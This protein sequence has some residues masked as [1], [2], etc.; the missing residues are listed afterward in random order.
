MTATSFGRYEVIAPLARGGMGEVYLAAL[1]SP[2]GFERKVVIKSVRA[3]LLANERMALMF[4]DEAR[5]AACLYHR[6]IVQTLE[7][8]LSPTGAYLVLEYVPGLDLFRLGKGLQAPMPYELAV[9]I[10]LEIAAALHHA[11]QAV[12]TEGQPLAIVHRD[13]TPSNVLLGDQGHVK[14]ADF[15]IAHSKSRL[16]ATRSGTLKGKCGYIAPEQIRG[17]TIDRRAD[18]FSLGVLFYEMT[19]GTSLYGHLKELE[20]MKAILNQ[21]LPEPA[22]ARRGYPRELAAVFPGLLAKDASAR[23]PTAAAFA[24]DLG[25]RAARLGLAARSADV[26]SAVRAARREART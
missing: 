23:Y 18:L 2:G 13:V 26:A 25:T 12:D 19:T 14:L 3:E 10:T 16:Y 5:I 22:G 6:N 24:D 9:Y 17:K 15:G 4:V 8:G 7:F 20:A 21:P 11:H 1:R